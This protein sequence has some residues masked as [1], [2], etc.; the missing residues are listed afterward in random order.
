MYDL[1]CKTV[2]G[3]TLLP[4]I[5]PFADVPKLVSFSYFLQC[6][7]IIGELFFSLRG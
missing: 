4:M 3:E 5:L 2:I 7:V 6:R 1:C